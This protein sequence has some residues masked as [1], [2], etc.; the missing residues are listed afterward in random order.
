MNDNLGRLRGV[1]RSTQL[2]TVDIQQRTEE[3]H[4]RLRQQSAC[5]RDVNFTSIQPQD[6]RTLFDLYD[7]R[8]LQCNLRSALGGTPLRF[9]LSRRMTS[10]GGKTVRFS[11]PTGAQY[12]ICVSTTLLFQSFHDVNR[13]IVVSGLKCQD[14]LQALQRIFEHE[15]LHLAEMLVWTNSNCAR[16]VFRSDG[17]R[18]IWS[19]SSSARTGHTAR[20]RQQCVWN[21]SGRSCSISLRPNGI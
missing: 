12:E 4:Q 5:V 20:G 10:A 13:P 6:L 2:A 16:A 19:H 21:S 14:R 17:P 3:I 11:T 8:F 9:R 1:Q 15:V 18:L 7:E